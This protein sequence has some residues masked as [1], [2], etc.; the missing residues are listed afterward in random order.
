MFD[1]TLSTN[2]LEAA[3]WPFCFMLDTI[4]SARLN[5]VVRGGRQHA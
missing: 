4:D 2:V 1:M 5:T 3:A